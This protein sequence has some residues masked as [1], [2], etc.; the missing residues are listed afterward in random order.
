MK[1]YIKYVSK[2]FSWEWYNI[3]WWRKPNCRNSTFWMFACVIMYNK[4]VETQMVHWS[5]TW[6]P[7]WLLNCAKNHYKRQLK[8]KISIGPE[9]KENWGRF[10]W[11]WQSWAPRLVGIWAINS[12]SLSVFSSFFFLLFSLE[13][14]HMT[15]LFLIFLLIFSCL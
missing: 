14:G 15:F 9:D 4:P 7:V 5:T 8:I 13:I 1:W 6:R 2:N 3:V 10:A 12:K 11:N